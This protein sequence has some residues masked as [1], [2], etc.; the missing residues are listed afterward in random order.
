M[1]TFTFIN[2]LATYGLIGGILPI[3]GCFK[4]FCKNIKGFIPVLA[5]LG[6]AVMIFST[7]NFMQITLLYIMM[8]YGFCA[9]EVAYEHSSTCN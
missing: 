3:V 8:F 2:L 4:F 9:K 1:A 6:F 5:M 7:E